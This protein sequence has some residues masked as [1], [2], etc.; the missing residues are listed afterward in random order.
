MLPA[1]YWREKTK[2]CSLING[3]LKEGGK[4]KRGNVDHPTEF[5]Q[6]QDCQI[7]G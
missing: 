7:I 6:N 5:F 2:V 3:K 4:K 1:R